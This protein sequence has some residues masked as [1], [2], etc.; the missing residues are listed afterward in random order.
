MHDL[1]PSGPESI[2]LSVGPALLSSHGC[3]Q[4]S[5]QD[6]SL[7]PISGPPPPASAET[8]SERGASEKT[9][10][11]ASVPEESDQRLSFLSVPQ[12]RGIV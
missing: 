11:R 8:G 5:S 9:G 1:S 7:T 2:C 6:D 3:L 10:S 12:T 4:V